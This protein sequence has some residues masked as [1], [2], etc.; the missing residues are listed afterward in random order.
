[1][2]LDKDM[3]FRIHRSIIFF[4]ALLFVPLLEIPDTG[5][6]PANTPLLGLRVVTDDNYPPYVFKENDGRLK[7]ILIDQWHLWEKK[8]GIRVQLHA[9]EW[10][11][12]QRRMLAGEFDVIDTLFRNEKRELIYEFSKPYAQIDVPIFFR[13]DISGIHDE[14]DLRGFAVGVKAGD[15]AIEVLKAKGVTNLIEFKSFEAI[16][17]AARDGKVNVFTVDK[18]PAF[19][20]LFKMGIQDRFNVSKP[21]YTGQFHRAV[22]K[23]QQ[24]ILEQVENGFARISKTEY[25]EIEKHWYGAPILSQKWMRYLSFG[26][27]VILLVLALLFL[28]LWNLRRIVAQRTAALEQEVQL[29]IQ[30]EKLLQD[31][32]DRFQSIFNAVN[33]SVF[34][35]E[36]PSFKIIDVNQTMCEM[37]GYSHEEA[38]QLSTEDFSASFAPYNHPENWLRKAITGKTLQF[39]WYS[40]HKTGRLFWTEIKMRLACI[41]SDDRIVVTVRDITERKQAQDALLEGEK[42]L[43]TFLDAIPESAFM[44]DRDGILLTLNRTTAEM[45]GKSPGDMLGKNIYDFIPEEVSKIRKEMVEKVLQSRQPVSF[46]DE[47]Q[48]RWIYNNISPVLDGGGNVSRVAVVGVDITER[49]KVELEKIKLEAQLLQAQKMEAI[50]LLAGGIAHDLNNILFPICGLSE[51]LLEDVPPD[52]RAYG[53]I[54]QIHKSAL[55]G[56]DLV[57]Q[58]L[59]FSRQSNPEKLPIRIQPIL[60]DVLRLSRAT[61]PQNIVITTHIESDCGMI[62]ANPAQMHQILLNLITNAYHAVEQAGGGSIHV[63][64][65]EVAINSF[66]NT[67][68]LHDDLVKSERYA[69]ILVRDTGAGIDQSMIDK[70]FTPYFTTKEPGKGTGIGL[71]V[72]HGIVKEYGGNIRV[73]SEV[74]SGTS[75]QVYLPLLEKVKDNK[76]AVV[77][78]NR[79]TGCERILLIDDEAPIADLVQMMLERLG[80]RI[81]VQTSSL[82]ALDDFRADPLKFDLVISDR[83]MPNM[84]GIQLARE[85]ISIRPEIPIIICTGFTDE[86]DEQCARDMGVKGFLI[87]PVAIGDLAIMVRNVLDSEVSQGPCQNVSYMA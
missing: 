69:C 53:S 50:G 82:D 7:G 8:T 76:S 77:T 52:T 40:K 13:T 16:V 32:N 65:K 64:L 10:D 42:N 24:A 3:C 70:I 6:D 33:E 43:K 41:G 71:S 35:H 60:K 58:I 14:N 66:G 44:M 30:Q 72:V 87:K 2:F 85:L 75:F 15:S 62:S 46:E 83:S 34:I 73:S 12:A 19:Y 37:Y 21:L 25:E 51:L 28:W 9:M 31:S 22:L 20:F 17:T 81:T 86:K 56:S 5:A 23:G 57:K 1:M 26:V 67:L 49:K 80:Y 4:V 29:R 48:N 63:A 47:R 61:I 55:R 45:F 84:T 11:E 18:P 68:E 27:V 79:P 39:E 36:L 59:A 78:G 74:G 54:E 38:L